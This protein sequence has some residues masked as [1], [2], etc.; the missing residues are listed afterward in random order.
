MF[1]ITL[2]GRSVQIACSNTALISPMFN[3]SLEIDI[4]KEKGENGLRQF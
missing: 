3:Y 2:N 4:V 1:I